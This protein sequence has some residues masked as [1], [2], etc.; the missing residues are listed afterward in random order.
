V[1]GMYQD[2]YVISATNRREH[3]SDIG[4][5]CSNN[6]CMMRQQETE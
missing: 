3:G 6:C 5:T 4:A 2:K 1:D